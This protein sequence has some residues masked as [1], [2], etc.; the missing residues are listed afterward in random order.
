MICRKVRFRKLTLICC[1]L[2]CITVPLFIVVYHAVTV[3]P[4]DTVT[5][6]I[7]QEVYFS[8]LRVNNNIFKDVGA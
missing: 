6:P 2:Y 1:I 3:D 5:N 4:I 7:A 8:N